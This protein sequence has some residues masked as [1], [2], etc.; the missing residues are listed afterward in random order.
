ME[1]LLLKLVNPGNALLHFENSQDTLPVSILQGSESFEINQPYPQVC[2]GQEA[3]FE[4]RFTGLDFDMGVFRMNIETMDKDVLP[5]LEFALV[6]NG[7]QTMEGTE[8]I[9]G[10]ITWDDLYYSLHKDILIGP[11]STL[12]IKSKVACSSESDIFVDRGGRLII[13]GGHLTGLCNELWNGIDVWG[14]AKQIQVNTYQGLVEVINDGIIEFADTAISTAKYNGIYTI[15]SGG[16]VICKDAVFKDNYV[17]VNF[18]PYVNPLGAYIPNLSRFSRTDFLITDDYYSLDNLIRT[19]PRCG[20]NMDGVHG[21]NIK[22]CNF[23]NGSLAEKRRRGSGII[24]MNAG[25]YIT[26]ICEEDNQNPCTNYL[27]S[28]FEGWD[29]GIKSLNDWSLNTITV[30]SADFIDNYRG[31]FMS[32]TSDATIIKNRFE[33]NADDAY[34]PNGDTLIGI[35]TEHCNRYQIEENKFTGLDP[36]TFKLVGMHILNSGPEF[37]EIYNDSLLN[38]TYGIVAAGENKNKDGTDGLCIKCNDFI[39]CATDIYITPDGGNDPDLSGIATYQGLPGNLAPPGTDPNSMGAGNTFTSDGYSLLDYNYYNSPGLDLIYYTHQPNTEQSKLR[40]FPYDNLEPIADGDVNYSKD[41]SCPSHL[42]EFV[43]QLQMEKNLLVAEDAQITSY[44]DTLTQYI[45]GGDTPGL[46]FEIQTSFP[47]DA[48]QLRQQLVDQSPYLS[49]TV[50]MS[51]IAKEDVLFNAM[52]RDILTANPQSAK[53]ADI[54]SALEN[55]FDPMPDYMMAEIMVGLDI[56]GGKE[57]LERNLARHQDLKARSFSRIVHYYK[58]DTVDASSRDSLLI[59]MED[60]FAILTHYQLIFCQLYIGDTT[61]AIN[62]LNSIPLDF[63]LNTLQLS[64]Q[65]LYHY[66]VDILIELQTDSTGIDSTLMSDLAALADEPDELPGIF[67]RNI[68]IITDL[69][70]YDEPVYLPANL[71]KSPVWDK[72]IDKSYSEE[73]FLKVFPNPAGTF[74]IIEYDLK[75]Y[76]GPA[77]ITISDLLG[78]EITEFNL[79]DRRNQRI[80]NTISFSSGTYLIKLHS[81]DNLFET[82]KVKIVR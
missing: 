63:S 4:I 16:I 32:L 58:N 20:M 44:Q 15:P 8:T 59:F 17:G 3:I 52:L 26:D 72:Q 48:L 19:A 13:D 47:E 25:Y 5:D 74:F 29:Y 62:A 68:L 78:R 79:K 70:P 22:G 30:D 9:S 14:D 61:A 65:N 28:R 50:M 40:P 31:I 2:M 81:N 53:S 33:L 1:Y 35:Y 49:D 39:D 75:N 56:L 69:I 36:G 51:A 10:D 6:Y 60:N 45:D 80:I 71:K 34:F 77:S 64:T 24:N 43:I 57:Q 23:T 37:N 7:C 46:D 12:T 11:Q 41:T 66:L 82:Q 67:A 18:A 76:T 38:L 21:I 42:N 55:K 54:L 27:P 73:K